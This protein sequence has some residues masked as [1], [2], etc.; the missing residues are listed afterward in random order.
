MPSEFTISQIIQFQRISQY[1]SANNK[2]SLMQLQSGSFIGILPKL[3]YMEGT[4]LQNLNSLNSGSPTL[5]GTGEYVLSLCGKYLVKAQQI[6]NA[7]AGTKPVLTGPANESTT[8]GTNAVFSVSAAGTGPFTYQWLLGGLP[9]AGANSSSYTVVNPQLTQN[10]TLYSAAVSNA[11]GTT[12][13]NQATL[14]VTATLV[15]SAYYS[16]IDPSPNINSQIDNFGYQFTIPITHNQP[17]AIPI[18][19]AAAN[20]MYWVWRVPNTEQV[21]NTWFNTVANNGQIP[22]FVFEAPASFGNYTYYYL[23]NA[24]SFDYTQTLILSKV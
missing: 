19:Q 5:R 1:I 2:S 18:P 13:S 17:I 3:L 16:N 11:A 22:D 8:V 23:R 24:T 6:L 7:L 20:N 9:I 4:L 10:G 21:D 14:T 12:V 15:L